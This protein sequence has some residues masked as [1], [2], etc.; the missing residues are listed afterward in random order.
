MEYGRRLAAS[1]VVHGFRPPLADTLSVIAQLLD[2]ARL[3]PYAQGV[4]HR[5][6]GSANLSAFHAEAGS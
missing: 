4:W 3:R 6:I 2:V 5:D 1:T